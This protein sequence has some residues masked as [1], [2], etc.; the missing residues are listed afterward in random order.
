VLFETKLSWERKKKK[1]AKRKKK[2]SMFF[3]SEKN[4]GK[5]EKKNSKPRGILLIDF[6][7]FSNTISPKYS[8]CI[9]KV[10][11]MNHKYEKFMKS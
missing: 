9:R 7:H 4:G 8:N 11:E 2:S 5:T 10:V 3:F 6:S 1:K